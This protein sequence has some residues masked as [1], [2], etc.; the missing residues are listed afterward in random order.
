MSSRTFY[1]LTKGITARPRSRRLREAGGYYPVLTLG[2]YISSGAGQVVEGGSNGLLE[3]IVDNNGVVVGIKALHDI[4]I[5]KDT[6]DGQEELRNV[7]E[8]LRHLDYRNVGTEQEPVY[9]LVVES[10]LWICDSQGVPTTNISELLRGYTYIKS[11]EYYEVHPTETEPE[12]SDDV[13]Y[14]ALRAREEFLDDSD[15]IKSADYYTEHEETAPEATD[16]KVYSALAAKENFISKTEDTTVSAVLTFTKGIKFGNYVATASGGSVFR[17]SD[18]A[19]HIEADYFHVRRKLTANEVEVQR[20]THIG[21][22]VINSPASMICSRVEEFG[23]YYRCYFNRDDADGRRIYNQFAVD[24]QALVQTFNLS[25]QAD[26]TAANHFLWR[27]VIA[28]GGDYIDLSKEDCASGSD[29]PLAGD[30]I[31][32]LG[33]RNVTSRQGAIIEA[34]VDASISSGYVPY[35]RVYQGIRNYSLPAPTVNLN[36]TRSSIQ[37]EFYTATGV[38]MTTYM[39]NVYAMAQ[40]AS[41]VAGNAATAASNAAMV[42]G[43]AATAASNAQTTANT[44]VNNA[45]TAKSRAD[46]AYDLA[47]SADGKADTNAASI[48]TLNGQVTAIA[49]RFNANGHLTELGYYVLGSYF[50]ELWNSTFYS[51]GT[52]KNTSGLVTT[53]DYATLMS[54]YFNNNGTLKNTAGLVVASGTGDNAFATLFASSVTSQGIAKT[55]E[56]QTWVRGQISGITL[57]ADQINFDGYTIINGNFEVDN[58]GNL[59]IHGGIEATNTVYTAG[60]VNYVIRAIGNSYFYGNLYQA[61]GAGSDMLQATNI[62]VLANSKL[63]L[64]AGGKLE[65]ASSGSITLEGKLSLFAKIVSSGTSLFLSQNSE[66]HYFLMKQSSNLTFYLGTVTDGQIVMVKQCEGTVTL[67]GSIRKGSS[68]VSSYVIGDGKT[69]ILVGCSDGYWSLSL[70]SSL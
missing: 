30:S 23:T 12:A 13:A 49:G 26:G 64:Y 42:A 24:D 15:I 69:A 47:D 25:R 1:N 35:I 21:G 70:T 37:G 18:D 62:S 44:A 52:L 33:N 45:A 59:K 58:S 51:N 27:L 17:D 22:R 60:N 38:N 19:W 7:T 29:A 65:I 48:S 67:S 5:I 63:S 16:E 41:T 55:A 40:D 14:S 4:S 11:T 68:T 32:Q 10:D 57:T 31:V 2:K 6:V 66:Y 39:S 9:G 46:S 43:N 36:P 54:Q 50:S 28:V 34:S 61:A 20:S 56:I 53:A 8:V 3:E